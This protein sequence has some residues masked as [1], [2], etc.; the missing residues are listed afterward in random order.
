MHADCHAFDDGALDEATVHPDVRPYLDAWKTFRQN[1]GLQPLTRERMVFDPRY[2]YCGT[3]DGI[4]STSSAR[5]LVLVDLKTGDPG[6]AAGYQTAA[7]LAAW[8]IEHPDV[9]VQERWAVQLTPE[10]AIPYRVFPYTDWRD[11][12]K[13]ASFCTTFHERRSA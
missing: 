8:A 6:A 2:F 11:F 1:T 3:L 10:N 12:T 7:Y 5:R 13:F 9:L 4:F